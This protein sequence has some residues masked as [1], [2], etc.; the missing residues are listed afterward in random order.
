MN[1]E[2]LPPEAGAMDSPRLA[3][4]KRVKVELDVFTH[5]HEESKWMGFSFTKAK[6]ALNGYLLTEEEAEHPIALF[7]AYCRLLDDANMVADH[8]PTEHD[9]IEFVAIRHGIKLWN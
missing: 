1:D 7:A 8:M 6:E 3:W 4:M 2:L 5:Y 9:A